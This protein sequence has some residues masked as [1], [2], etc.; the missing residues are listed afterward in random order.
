MYLA[1]A[2]YG[3]EPL[4]LYKETICIEDAENHAPG[5]ET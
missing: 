4:K 3:A 1:D 2:E 5:T